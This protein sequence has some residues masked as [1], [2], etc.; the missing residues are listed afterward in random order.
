MS[1][2]ILVLVGVLAGVMSGMFGIGGGIVIV[3]ALVLLAGFSLVEATGTSLAAI[4]LPVGL[5][6]VI[7]YY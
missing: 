2:A 3:P 4:L 6:G 5:L 7:A 1:V